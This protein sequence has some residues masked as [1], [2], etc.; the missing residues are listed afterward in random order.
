[1]IV[2]E[3][4][5]GGQ[6]YVIRIT[7]GSLEDAHKYLQKV[8]SGDEIFKSDTEV[9]QILAPVDHI[10]AYV[11]EAPVCPICKGRGCPRCKPEQYET[12]PGIDP[13]PTKG[14]SRWLGHAYLHKTSLTI[15]GTRYFDGSMSYYLPF[16]VNGV[17]A[18]EALSQEN[19]EQVTQEAIQ[20]FDSGTFVI[21]IPP[22]QIPDWAEAEAYVTDY[23]EQAKVDQPV[24]DK[25]ARAY[26]A[27]N[28]PD[29]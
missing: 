20:D 17:N 23:A 27:W 1:M 16:E 11:E 10:R 19:L 13:N 26:K 4:K 3:I 9:L 6:T 15:E 2:G 12:Q 8:A 18:V 24:V 7:D 28:N 22:A 29:K 14:V 25:T 21:V 5:A